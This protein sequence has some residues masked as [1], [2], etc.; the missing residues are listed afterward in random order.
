MIVPNLFFFFF[1]FFACRVCSFS[2][3]FSSFSR[4]FPSSLANRIRFVVSSPV[5]IFLCAASIS[6]YVC[7]FK[8]SYTVVTTSQSSSMKCAVRGANV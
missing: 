4:A 2:C 5:S 8:W 3:R 7:S 1:F 6:S